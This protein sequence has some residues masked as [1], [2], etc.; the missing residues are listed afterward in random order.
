MRTER[1]V[2]TRA[3]AEMLL[4][5]LDIIYVSPTP[6]QRDAAFKRM[7]EVFQIKQHSSLRGNDPFFHA[8]PRGAAKRVGYRR[9]ALGDTAWA[10]F[11]ICDREVMHSGLLAPVLVVED[12]KS[13]NIISFDHM[14]TRCLGRV[15]GFGPIYIEVP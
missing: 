6:E 13:M 10:N 3:V 2:V 5:G 7:I 9:E 1:E 15:N 8:D 4:A 14:R 11:V 12:M